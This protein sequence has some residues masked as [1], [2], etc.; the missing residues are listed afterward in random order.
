MAYLIYSHSFS[1]IKN[2]LFYEG[3]AKNLHK[4]QNNYLFYPCYNYLELYE[5]L[6]LKDKNSN[7]TNDSKL[8][9]AN[10]L[11]LALEFCQGLRFKFIIFSY[12]N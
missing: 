9:V 7:L 6:E 10:D 12:I 4:P 2:I 3:Y 5:D 8:K 1:L 11:E